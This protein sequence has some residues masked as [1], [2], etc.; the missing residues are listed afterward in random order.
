[1]KMKAVIQ[2]KYGP[3]DVLQIQDIEKPT[4]VDNQVLIKVRAASVNAMDYRALR[5]RPYFIRLMGYGFLTP[6]KKLFGSDIAGRIETVGKNVTQFQPGDEV[7]G[8]ARGG[9]SE[10]VCAREDRLAMKPT[11]I[12]FEQAAATPVAALTALQSLRDKGQIKPGQKVLIDGA[13]GGVGTFAV[14]IAK[15]LGA[16]LTAVCRTRNVDLVRSLGA[17][18]VI[19]ST[20]EDFTKDEERYDLIL[21]ANGYHSI[22]AYPRALSPKGT[23]VLAGGAISLF[24]QAMLLGPLIS[25]IRSKKMIGFVA[26]L[27]PKDLNY[28]KDLLEAGKVVPVI[29]KRYTL[30]Q[31]AEAV[32]YLED[33]HAQGKVV[34]T[35]E[36]NPT[37]SIKA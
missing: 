7:F 5:G 15:F 28:M 18:H 4:P 8:T 9:F 26:Q 12:S 19:D 21:A 14:Q 11:N 10:Y 34:V 25:K 37:E 31:A 16:E 13:S 24:F 27:N 3:P 17:D 2:T 36:D 32:R 22:F 33:V 30:G 6:K 23:F 20:K 29:D 1:M 35:L